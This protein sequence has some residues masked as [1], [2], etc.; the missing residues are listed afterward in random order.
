LVS[1]AEARELALVARKQ[2]LAGVDPINARN[3]ARARVAAEGTK[4]IT[5]KE[6]AEQYYQLHEQK[7]KN[8]KRR[9]QFSNTLRTYAF[10]VLGAMPVD[11]ISTGDVLRV[12]DPI[13]HS[14]TETASRVRQRIEKVLAW[15]IVRGY[16]SA[17]NPAAWVNHLKEAL[18]Q[19]KHKRTEGPPGEA[20][21]LFAASRL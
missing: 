2:L 12:L 7:W 9:A 3:A 6:A 18:P 17:P 13:W 16:R 10:P 21:F 4:R 11:T 14:K 19:T 1:F 20:T 5:F 8:R 15:S